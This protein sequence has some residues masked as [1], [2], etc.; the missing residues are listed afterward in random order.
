MSKFPSRDEFLEYE[1]TDFS[2]LLASDSSIEIKLTKVGD[3]QETPPIKSFA[4]TFLAPQGSG[5]EAQVYCLQNKEMGEI[6]IFLS[7]FW[8]SEE[9]LKLEAIFN[10][11]SEN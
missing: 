5:L 2:L 6:D 10:Q 4:L 8:E 7:P 1:G 9:G 11:V 3:L